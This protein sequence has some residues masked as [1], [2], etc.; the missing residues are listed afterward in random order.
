MCILVTYAVF[1]LEQAF[2]HLEANQKKL[3][4]NSCKAKPLYIFMG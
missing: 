4:V 3:L 1:V 2:R